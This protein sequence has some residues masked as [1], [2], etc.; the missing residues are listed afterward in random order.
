MHVCMYAC[1]YMCVCMH[2]CVC[3]CMNVC[4]HRCIC[5]CMD[6]CMH[7]CVCV[8]MYAC[9]YICMHVCVC[10]A[11]AWCAE[12]LQKQPFPYVIMTK[13]KPAGTPHNTPLQQGREAISYLQFIIDYY[14]TLPPRMIFVHGHQ[15]SWH[16]QVCMYV[17]VRVCVCVYACMLMY[18][19][20]V[21]LCVCVYDVCVCV[22]V[23]VCMCV[24][25]QSTP[26][27][28]RALDPFSYEYVGI[29]ADF[30]KNTDPSWYKYLGRCWK[31]ANMTTWMPEGFP[32]DVRAR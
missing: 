13:G 18:V 25:L 8:C 28:L 17:C 11:F 16:Q 23:Y 32:A 19:C 4:M 29:S 12:W 7:V 20:L 15:S 6:A 9:V 14:D 10:P 24:W 31:L 3:A 27:V 5:V 30:S 1:V 21:C 2:E 22:C 26:S